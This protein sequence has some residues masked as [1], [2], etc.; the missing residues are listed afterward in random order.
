VGARLCKV[1]RAARST[2][3]DVNALV[4]EQYSS[5]LRA[6]KG[7]VAVVQLPSVHSLV[8][9]V[10]ALPN[11][12]E[13]YAP[14]VDACMA[15]PYGPLNSFAVFFPYGAV[16]LFGV[17]DAQHE[18]L[19]EVA[20]PYVTAG[21][22]EKPA[23]DDYTVIL[24]MQ[25][26]DWCSFQPDR[27]TVREF[28]LNSIRVISQVL[29]Q[30]VAMEHYEKQTNHMLETFQALNAKLGA[31]RALWRSREQLSKI[32]AENNTILNDMIVQLKVL[33]RSDTAWRYGKYDFL[34]I[35]M[36]NEFELK[37]RFEALEFKVTHVQHNIKFFLEVVQSQRSARLEW[38]IVFLIATEVAIAL[39]GK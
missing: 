20:S 6:V 15:D 29:A 19:L 31:Q 14:V 28:D 10:R 36:R 38:I 12:A 37:A 22:Q 39:F 5:R 33:D 27:V 23:S 21:R 34:W 30:T 26:A 25:A 9:E 8:A 2:R 17:P 32:L 7:N 4:N 18:P 35:G 3:L 24:K 1:T 11:Y 16:V 13:D